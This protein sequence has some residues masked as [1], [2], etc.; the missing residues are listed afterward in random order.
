[1]WETRVRALGWEVPLEKEMSTHSSILAW[2]IPWM[3][4]PGRQQSMGSQSRTRLSDFTFFQCYNL[5]KYHIENWTLKGSFL[6][7]TMV[8]SLPANAGDSRDSGLIR[9][10]GRSPE[11]GST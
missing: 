5:G 3:E 9:G 4:D 10:S 7:G 11:V 1:M 8:K 6:G 2:T